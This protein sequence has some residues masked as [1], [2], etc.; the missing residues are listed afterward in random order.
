[1][2]DDILQSREPAVMIEP[3]LRVTPES[4]KRGRTVHV[5]R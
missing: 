4:G 3:A 5:G 1:M 2:F